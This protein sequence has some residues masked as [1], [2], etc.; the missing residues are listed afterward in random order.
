VRWVT[1]PAS[2]SVSFLFHSMW[3]L[4]ACI[5]NGTPYI[6]KSVISWPS[7][8]HRNSYCCCF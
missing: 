6:Y 8:P 7:S 3:W 4:L 5:V 1:G 2:A